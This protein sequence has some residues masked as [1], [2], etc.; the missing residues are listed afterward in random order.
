MTT[1]KKANQKNELDFLISDLNNLNS[2]RYKRRT[3]QMKKRKELF[4]EKAS[5]KSYEEN[6]NEVIH[7][8]KIRHLY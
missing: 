3:D 4:E 2:I 6:K 8:I 7:N 1:P 5:K